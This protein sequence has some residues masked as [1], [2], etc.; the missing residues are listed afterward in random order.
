MKTGLLI[1]DLDSRTTLEQKVA[2]AVAAY[3]R[4]HGTMPDTCAVNSRLQ[5]IP[6]KVGTVR[7]VG[8]TTVLL[9]DYWV[10]IEEQKEG[11]SEL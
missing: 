5:N 9:G 8:M 11:Q 10:G 7:V 4:K 3:C 2:V 1:Q 6:S